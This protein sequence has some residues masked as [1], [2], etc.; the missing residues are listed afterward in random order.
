[1][2]SFSA[3]WEISMQGEGALPLAQLSNNLKLGYWKR[4]L[5]FV[6][7][8]Q[9]IKKLIDNCASSSAPGPCI[10]IPGAGLEY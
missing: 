7:S 8:K 9:P 3:G 5:K 2:T 10:E 4:K 6:F 1:M